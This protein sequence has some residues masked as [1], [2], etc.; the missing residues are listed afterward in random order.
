MSVTSLKAE[1]LVLKGKI[2]RLAKRIEKSRQKRNRTKP[3]QARNKL[4][5]LIISRLKLLNKYYGQ[6]AKLNEDILIAS[7]AKLFPDKLST[8]KR[9]LDLIKNF[10]GFVPSILDDG[11][12]NPTVGYGHVVSYRSDSTSTAINKRKEFE[13]KYGKVLSIE[14]AT[15]LLISDLKTKYELYV[16]ET[17]KVPISQS[18]FNAIVSAV[19]N[20]GPEFVYGS[21]FIKKLNALDYNGAANEFLKWDMANGKH[22]DGLARRRKAER[23][24]FL[25]K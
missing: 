4:N 16:K 17:V 23:K 3:S 14:D 12:G 11:F 22:V 6:L 21:T 2:S 24:L 20:L 5:S 25:S 8:S 7:G 13:H 19:Y 1:R 15:D 18:Q 9:G 10:E